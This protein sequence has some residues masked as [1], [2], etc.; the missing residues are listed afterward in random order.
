ML[1][2]TRAET[3]DEGLA[4]ALLATENIL[5][6]AVRRRFRP[7]TPSSELPL[8]VF[9]LQ[10]NPFLNRIVTFR[11]LYLVRILVSKFEVQAPD[12]LYSIH[13]YNMLRSFGGSQQI[14]K[15]AKHMIKQFG[16]RKIFRRST[17]PFTWP[18]ILYSL[19]ATRQHWMNKS[20]LYPSELMELTY[21]H[22]S[23]GSPKALKV[24]KCII[25][26]LGRSAK[27]GNQGLTIGY[28]HDSLH[29]S[30]SPRCPERR[31]DGRRSMRSCPDSLGYS[32]QQRQHGGHRERPG[33]VLR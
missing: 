25:Q 10:R 3:R 9:H 5:T 26:H 6:D 11:L 28:P 22:L 15:E 13:F 16:C 29:Y 17:R 33:T 23:N 27:Y 19:R 1:A 24:Q 2:I 4:A 20:F 32:R 14:W 8:C 30:L 18:D 31:E 12:L 7:S 21:T